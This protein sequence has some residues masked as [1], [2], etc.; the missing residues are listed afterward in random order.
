[1]LRGGGIELWVDP[2]LGQA[3]RLAVDGRTLLGSSVQA[4][5]PEPYAA[6]IEGH[7]LTLEHPDGGLSLRYE[8]DVGRRAVEVTQ[9]LVNTSSERALVF[10]LEQQD[11]AAGSGLSILSGPHDP[12]DRSAPS[13]PGALPLLWLSYARAEESIEAIRE[14]G[15]GWFAQVS[16]SSLLVKTFSANAPATLL[17]RATYLSAAQ[18]PHVFL[19]EQCSFELAPGASASFTSRWLLRKLPPGIEA[20][21]RNPELVRFIRGIVR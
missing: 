2:A 10:G 17:V 20:K 18:P 5:R 6:R 8:L 4:P 7:A 16:A 13:A 1:M 14:P 11:L 12:P 15:Q 19:D 21:P 3:T 9:R